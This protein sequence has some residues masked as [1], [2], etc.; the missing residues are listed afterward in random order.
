MINERKMRVI[1]SLISVANRTG[2]VEFARGLE[3]FGVEIVTSEEIAQE[4]REAEI[5][6]RTV[7]EYT[8]LTE[9]IIGG[10][11]KTFHHVIYAGI[12]A[13]RDKD[14]EDIKRWNISKIDMVV[15]NFHLSEELMLQRSLDDSVIERMDVENLS[16]LWAAIQNHERVATVV[17]PE[18]YELVLEAMERND[19]CIPQKCLRMLAEKASES[20]AEYVAT[21]R[22]YFVLVCLKK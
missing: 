2:T 7:S 18:D 8:G 12:R 4:L 11:I 22:N 10:R 21:V 6:H 15:A 19:G 17:D 20:V 5:M 14:D 16:L 1:R 9:D 13:R 3:S